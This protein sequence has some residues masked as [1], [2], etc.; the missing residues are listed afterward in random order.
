MVN[1]ECIY[2]IYT[3]CL[4]SLSGNAVMTFCGIKQEADLTV[5]PL[6]LHSIFQHWFS[7]I[8]SPVPRLPLVMPCSYIISKILF[9]QSKLLEDRLQRRIDI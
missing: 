5:R 7:A 1:L 6:L 3:I 8:G 2:N 4:L 9:K